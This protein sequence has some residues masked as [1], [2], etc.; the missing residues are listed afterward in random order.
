M[1]ER[2]MFAKTIIDS[3]VFLDMPL[4]TQALYFHLSMRADD[5]GFI[6]NPR[7]IQRMIGASDD[8][9]RILI[10]KRFIITFDSGIVVIKHWRIHNYI[11]N[12]RFKP[13]AYTE[14]REMLSIKPNKAYTLN[15]M[16]MDTECIQDVS[17]MDIQYRLGKDRLGKDSIDKFKEISSNEDI[18]KNASDDA[19]I[20]PEAENVNKS[21]DDINEYVDERPVEKPK[22]KRKVF[23]PPT[24]EEVKAYAAEK[25]FTRLNAESFV[26]YYE[27][28]GWMIGRNKMKNWK[29]AASGWEIREKNYNQQSRA[30]PSSF[31]QFT[32]REQTEEQARELERKL[33]G[34]VT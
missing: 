12:D 29:A 15:K 7:K 16:P 6:N 34:G 5:E 19:D 25:G 31:N 8:D 1:A 24:V 23:K 21:F 3:D 27:S 17:K 4:S 28:K 33:L 20:L 30:R 22:P 14:E 18:K 32:G 26:A 2:R 10:S 11:Q 9:L 13:T